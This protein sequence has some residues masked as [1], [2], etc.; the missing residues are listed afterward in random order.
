MI[1]CGGGPVPD[2]A[3]A[4]IKTDQVTARP[5]CSGDTFTEGKNIAN[6]PLPF[7]TISDASVLPNAGELWACSH[8]LVQ[9]PL[10]V[11]N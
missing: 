3:L 10:E 1:P 9:L 5:C 7:V 6:R 11:T 8:L 4:A 2:P